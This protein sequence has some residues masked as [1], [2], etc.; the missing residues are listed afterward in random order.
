MFE[1][2][3]VNI[4][5]MVFYVF[6]NIFKSAS[7][8]V[9]RNLIFCEQLKF[10]WGKLTNLTS[11]V[12]QNKR[13]VPIQK[14]FHAVSQRKRNV[15][16]KS[17]DDVFPSRESFFRDTY[18]FIWIKLVYICIIHRCLCWNMLWWQCTRQEVVTWCSVSSFGFLRGV[19]TDLTIILHHTNHHEIF[20]MYL[21]LSIKS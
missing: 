11:K 20:Q 19:L 3:I 1:N 17:T 4:H 18:S 14:R 21:D 9:S 12:H 7:M 5:Y 10:N 8:S 15:Q 2:K 6:N 13:I 16:R